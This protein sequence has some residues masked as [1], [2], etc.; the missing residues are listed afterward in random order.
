[1]R[2]HQ[3]IV[4]DIL[5]RSGMDLVSLRDLSNKCTVLSSIVTLLKRTKRVTVVNENEIVDEVYYNT[6]KKD[7]CESF[8]K[9]RVPEV[10]KILRSVQ[11][12]FFAHLLN[13]R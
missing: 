6:F 1:M 8:T 4:N 2:T 13:Y 12:C 3:E 9:K 10:L 7:V 11:L 5:D